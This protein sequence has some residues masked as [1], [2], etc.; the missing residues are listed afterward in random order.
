MTLTPEQKESLEVLKDQLALPKWS[1]KIRITIMNQL[2]EM[3][4]VELRKTKHDAEF[5]YITEL[6]SEALNQ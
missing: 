3:G 2:L 6:G 5:W 4:L 1:T